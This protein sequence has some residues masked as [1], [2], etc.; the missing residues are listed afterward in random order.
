VPVV[1]VGDGR[2]F[3]QA[4]TAAVRMAVESGAG[5]TVGGTI[6]TK[7]D[8]VVTDVLSAV[9]RGVVTRY[10]MLDSADGALGVHV[11]I[12]AMV[13][14]IAERD[15]VAAGGQ[16]LSVPGA[17]WTAN[18]AVD[19]QRIAQEGQ[20]LSDIFGSVERQPNAFAYAVEAGPPVPS[21]SWMRL[22]LRVV[23]TPSAA[24]SALLDRAAAVLGAVAGPAGDRTVHVPIADSDVL[25]VRGCVSRCGSAERQVLDA[26]AALDGTD[27]LGGFDPPVVTSG[28]SAEVTS[29]FPDLRTAGGF[30]V[31]FVDSVHQRAELTHVR[32]TRGYLAM[33]DYL[34]TTFDDA[35]LRLVI[36]G[37]TADLFES[38]RAPWSG[39]P[40][41]RIA[42]TAPAGALPMAL[43]RGFRSSTTG[44]P[45]APTTVGS[46][47]VVLSLPVAGRRPDT[48]L[49][50]AWVSPAQLGAL[51]EIRI[52]PLPT[53]HRLGTVTCRTQRVRWA[54]GGA[55]N[56]KRCDRPEPID[57][58]WRSLD[59]DARFVASPPTAPRG[60]SV[61][62]TVPQAVKDA[63][64]RAPL[65]D[66][67][68]AVFLPPASGASLVAVGTGIVDSIAP[69]QACAVARLRAQREMLRV[70]VGSRLEGRIA[71]ASSEQRGSAVQ[72]TF[73][74]EI[75]ETV[76]GRLVGAA[77][78]SQWIEPSPRRCR[79]AL[80]LANGIS[81]RPDS[82]GAARPPAPPF[83]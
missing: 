81:V 34:R 57:G 11:R 49:V 78:G 10:V 25:R 55:R 74:E 73:R 59:G 67:D 76:A 42:T 52:E 46:P 5:A 3:Q 60:A 14:R 19:S 22:R 24:Y 72:E 61:Q 66:G 8:R 63:L 47:Y 79:V 65:H 69:S 17:L 15:A 71:L 36:G 82:T 28:Q 33:V 48:A 40:R 77:L 9:S 18:A 1:A 16:R 35:R 23:R 58:A 44:G 70:L 83:L 6:A 32:S 51:T 7:G 27:S 53:T 12:L 20:L 80:W 26:R 41:H 4:L 29:L 21:G 30:V 38:F 2:S 64:D 56:V 62:P 31:S 43:V 45:G 75:T 39:Q 13:S 50:D 37:V 68:G 54:D